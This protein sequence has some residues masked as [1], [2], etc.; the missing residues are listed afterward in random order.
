MKFTIETNEPLGETRVVMTSN[1]Y[2][3]AF[4]LVNSIIL[5]KQDIDTKQQ[6]LPVAVALLVANYCGEVFEFEGIRIGN[7]HADAIRRIIG[8]DVSVLN[9]DGMQRT[10]STGEID[11]QCEKATGRMPVR[12]ALRPDDTTPF[13][14]LDWSG[15]PVS[16]YSRNSWNSAQGMI[17]TNA[18][19]FA[20]DVTVSVAM[21]LI[22]GRG[23]VRTIHVAEGETGIDHLNAV[24]RPIAV[25]VAELV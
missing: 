6:I 5:R 21:A 10:V 19:L 13:L 7:D 25:S 12:E 14:K 15:D 23:A 1:C 3:D 20:D 16:I 18:A 9:V 2:T 22:Y 17:H 11:I 4:P 8:R 24:L